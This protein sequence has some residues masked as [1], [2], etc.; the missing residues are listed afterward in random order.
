MKQVPPDYAIRYQYYSEPTPPPDHY[1]YT[2]RIDPNSGGEIVFSPDYHEGHN[3]IETLNLETG[4]VGQLYSLMLESEVFAKDWSKLKD[5]DPTWLAV[6]GRDSESFQ[7]TAY[8]DNIEVSCHRT[9]GEYGSINQVYTAIRALVPETVWG[10]LMAQQEEYRQDYYKPVIGSLVTASGCHAFMFDPDTALLKLDVYTQAESEVDLTEMQKRRDELRIRR[11][12]D[13][14]V[15]EI[16]IGEYF[17]DSCE[18]WAKADRHQWSLRICMACALDRAS[19]MGEYYR[20]LPQMTLSE[21]LVSGIVRIIKRLS[22][23]G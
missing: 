19:E 6:S 21:R 10:K 23:R 13:N 12:S 4:D 1:Q 11:A 9:Q 16:R 5:S 15:E 2:I 20:N 17:C 7:V 14:S 18:T 22:W 8:G 3:W